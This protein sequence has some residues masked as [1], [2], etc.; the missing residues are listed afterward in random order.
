MRLPADALADL[1]LRCAVE[2]QPAAQ[3]TALRA[4]WSAELHQARAGAG[5]VGQLRFAA[6]LVRC[7]MPD[8]AGDVPAAER[9]SGVARRLV[10]LAAM[11]V[12]AAVL[13]ST[14]RT[15][16]VVAVVSVAAPPRS[17]WC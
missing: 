16:I 10:P 9:W 4:E 12:L 11:P 8:S 5:P 13:L 7:R 6:G 15:G 14:V 17:G 3:R 2:R 1:L